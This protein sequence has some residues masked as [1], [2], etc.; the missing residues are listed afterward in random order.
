MQMYKIFRVQEQGSIAIKTTDGDIIGQLDTDKPSFVCNEII[1]YAIAE[2]VHKFMELG[3]VGVLKLK[4]DL[5]VA[6]FGFPEITNEPPKI[7][8]EEIQVQNEIAP[9]E[10]PPKNTTPIELDDTLQSTIVMRR[11]K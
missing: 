5:P 11:K 3:L 4:E 9:V 8:E 1:Y 10:R 7:V 6:N 2:N